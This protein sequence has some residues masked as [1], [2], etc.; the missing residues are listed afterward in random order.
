MAAPIREQTPIGDEE[1]TR[2]IEGGDPDLAE[3]AF[4][5]RTATDEPLLTK[6]GSAVEGLTAG[7]VKTGPRIPADCPAASALR[8]SCLFNEEQWTIDSPRDQPFRAQRSTVD[9]DRLHKDVN[10]GPIT[11]RAH[12]D[13]TFCITTMTSLR[14]HLPQRPEH[15]RFL[16]AE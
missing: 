6:R 13:E 7:M 15:G 8:I 12:L 2:A 1:L 5:L 9:E 11:D 3:F 14:N 10:G 16:R 4:R